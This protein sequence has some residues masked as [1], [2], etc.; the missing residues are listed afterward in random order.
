VSEPLPNPADEQLAQEIAASYQASPQAT[1]RLLAAL[2]GAGGP[3]APADWPFGSGTE[4]D[5]FHS[6]PGFSLDWTQEQMQAAV[7]AGT[8]GD[9]VRESEVNPQ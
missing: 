7:T 3:G 6:P 4:A 9:A 8:I 5:P 1:E 2:A